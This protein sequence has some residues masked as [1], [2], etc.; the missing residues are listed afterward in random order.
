MFT[1]ILEKNLL[2]Y[3][4]AAVGAIGIIGKLV[5]SATIRRLTKAAENMSKSEHRLMKLIRAKYEHASMVS[6]KVQNVD[7]FV[8][9]YL[10]EYKAWGLKLHTWR[11]LEKQMIW[12]SGVV[13]AVGAAGS[14]GAAGVDGPLR[15]YAA[16]GIAEM[17]ILYLLYQWG[18]EAHA[19]NM[20]H[21]YIV[22][23][24]ENV[25]AH[26]MAKLYHNP[27]QGG[28]QELE[29]EAPR[30]PIFSA[31]MDEPVREPRG[32]YYELPRDEGIQFTEGRKRD[33]PDGRLTGSAQDIGR[34]NGS[35]QDM[36]RL[37]GAGQDMSRL[38]GA[39]QDMGRLAGAGQD[40]GRLGGAGQDMGRLAGSAQDMRRPEAAVPDAIHS[41]QKGFA[42]QKNF[43]GQEK[44][45]EQEEKRSSAVSREQ[46]R[47][48]AREK[49]R[50]AV[51]G[52]DNAKKMDESALAIQ[53]DEA[54]K[55]MEKD[56]EERKVIIREILEQYLA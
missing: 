4:M 30:Q 8:D 31:N 2:F 27:A 29:T 11:Q 18:D 21:T 48:A 26:R 19:W 41:A 9:K 20:I 28:A 16:A 32:S 3:L 50:E 22:D 7:A 55:N 52:T 23:Y 10:F 12:L 46:R 34:L 37:G 49:V 25:C 36:G 43:A 51:I 5:F 47:E 33:N 13:A 45:R 42:D 24:L 53:L 39:G 54:R 44:L 17:I 35:A 1:V 56:S 6:D 38:G 15:Y 14:Y 40:M